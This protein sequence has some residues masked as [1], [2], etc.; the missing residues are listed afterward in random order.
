[1]ADL[2]SSEDVVRAVLDIAAPAGPRKVT[3]RALASR[4]NVSVGALYNYAGSMDQAL[5]SADQQVAATLVEQMPTESADHPVTSWAAANP[6][7]AALLFDLR[8]DHPE[9]P[10]QIRSDFMGSESPVPPDLI[11]EMGRTFLGLMQGDPAGDALLA[12]IDDWV[13][14]LAG[15]AARATER[16]TDGKVAETVEFELPVIVEAAAAVAA[17]RSDQEAR[18][19]VR[20]ANLDIFTGD[21]GWNFRALQSATGLPLARLHLMGTRRDHL[22]RT[23]SDYLLGALR[24]LDGHKPQVVISSLVLALAHVPERSV[25]DCA[26]LLSFTSVNAISEACGIAGMVESCVAG[27]APSRRLPAGL[28]EV[29]AIAALLSGFRCSGTD[30]GRLAKSLRYAALGVETLLT[31]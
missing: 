5:A 1:M 25:T 6:G 17:E 22:E 20:Q 31:D 12:S 15:S 16:F 11:G 29:S 2:V 8:R 28:I 24:L 23:V 26:A 21:D 18:A 27:Q 30:P 14:S 13:E 19:R 10:E 7:H 9:L 4:L 3:A